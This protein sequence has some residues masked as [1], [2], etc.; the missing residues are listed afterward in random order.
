MTATNQTTTAIGDFVQHHKITLTS[1]RTD[2]NP[3]MADSRDMDHHRC[4]LRCGGKRMT[5]IFSMGVGHR[6]SPPESTDVLSCLASDASGVEDARSF[7]EWC[8][9]LGFDADSRT[10]EKT[11]KVIIKQA[12]KL[13]RLLGDDAYRDLIGADYGN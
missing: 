10:A 13:K 4:V 5:L 1:E 3:N 2:A 8:S 9:E 7:E 12:I 11:Y 6:G